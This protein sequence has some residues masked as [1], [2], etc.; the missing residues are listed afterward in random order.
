VLSF[1]TSYFAAID[2]HD[3]TAYQQL[4]SPPLSTTLSATAFSAG[5]GTTT[6]SAIT[7]TS[8]GVAGS[9]GLVAQVT[10]VSHQEPAAS[11]TNSACTSWNVSLYLLEQGGSYLLEQP[12]PG[13]Q[14]F[15][16][17]CS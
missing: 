12:P 4:F 3:F 10:F 1:L 5:Y 17:A 14:A 16:A 8:I 7:L 11:P 6:D 2:D 13:Y 15:Y 9:G